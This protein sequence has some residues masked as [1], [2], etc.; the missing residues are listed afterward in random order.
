[1]YLGAARTCAPQV[2]GN[3]GAQGTRRIPLDGW[4]PIT[5]HCREVGGAKLSRCRIV[6]QPN[7][8]SFSDAEIVIV[9]PPNEVPLDV[10]KHLARHQSS[11]VSSVLPTV[12]RWSTAVSSARTSHA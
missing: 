2:R 3:E 11:Q 9:L 1:M 10:R 4:R 5:V 7:T 8:W 12:G 6:R